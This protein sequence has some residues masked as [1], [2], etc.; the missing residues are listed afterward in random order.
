[1]SSKHFTMRMHDD[2]RDAAKER[3]A[4]DPRTVQM[5]GHTTKVTMSYVITQALWEYVNTGRIAGHDV[6]SDN[7]ADDGTTPRSTVST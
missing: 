3:A 5:H 6:P 1:M 7:T 2:L 4:H